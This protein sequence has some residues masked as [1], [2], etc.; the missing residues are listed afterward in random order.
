MKLFFAAFV[1]VATVSF[2]SCSKDDDEKNDY[3]ASTSYA[4]HYQDGVLTPG[5]TVVHTVT[6]EERANGEALEAFFFENKTANALQTRYK[7]ELVEGPESMSDVPVC[8][9]ECRVVKCPFNSD[10]FSLAPGVDSKEFSIHCYPDMHQA[11]SKG[12]YKITVGKTGSMEDPQVF[13][14]QFVL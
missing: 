4:I 2:V 12:T 1:M 13:F 9:G 8:Y 7:V 3:P 6:A 5:Q 14:L 10:V 11:G